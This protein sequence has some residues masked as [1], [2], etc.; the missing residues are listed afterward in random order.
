M[1]ASDHLSG[2]QLREYGSLIP[3]NIG[4]WGPQLRGWTKDNPRKAAI[5]LAQARTLFDHPKLGMQ[6]P[7]PNRWSRESRDA[8]VSL[9]HMLVHGGYPA[10]K[11]AGAFVSQHRDPASGTSSTAHDSEGHVGA[12]LHPARWDY[13]TLAHESAHL[14]TMHDN[15]WRPN[16]RSLGDGQVHGGQFARHHAR[17]LGTISQDAGDDF[18][19]HRDRFL[20]M[21]DNYRHRVHGMDRM[22]PEAD[23]E[24][25][26]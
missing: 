26:S 6:L 11:A 1:S 12:A 9:E 25:G 15:D 13:G 17:A 5:H 10:G 24:M 16:D 23:R 8:G 7:E 19:G 22:A 21:I 2:P 18:L 20:G 4:T 3:D 14:N